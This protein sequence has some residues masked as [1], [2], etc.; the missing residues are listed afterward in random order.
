MR[1]GVLNMQYNN[2]KNI[3][4]PEIT[5]VDLVEKEIEYDRQPLG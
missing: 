4:A 3:F 2:I 1:K 5:N